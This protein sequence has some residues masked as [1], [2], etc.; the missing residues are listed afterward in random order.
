[1]LELLED[2]WSNDTLVEIVVSTGYG[3]LKGRICAVMPGVIGLKNPAKSD[4]P[5]WVAIDHIV[6]IEQVAS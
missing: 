2:F 5:A 3:T 1:M 4:F 6:L